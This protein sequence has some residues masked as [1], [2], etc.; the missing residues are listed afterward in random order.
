M[1]S[2]RLRRSRQQERTTA[3]LHGG[4]VQPGSGNSWAR[5][6]DVRTKL[7]L[8]ENKRTD[9]TQITLKDKDLR[10][11]WTEAWSEGRMPLIGFEVGG[12]RYIVQLEDDYLEQ[13]EE[14]RAGAGSATVVESG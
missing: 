9:A 5:K 6:G 10:K 14:R 12:R 2:D 13:Q 1:Q 8:I 7:T 11:I 3:R 4:R